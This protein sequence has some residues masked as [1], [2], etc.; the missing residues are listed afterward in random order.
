VTLFRLTDSGRRAA[1]L[2]WFY[3]G[4]H[5]DDEK[6]VFADLCRLVDETIEL[7]KKDGRALPRPMSVRDRF[8]RS[9]NIA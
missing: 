6:K 2:A 1:Q 9:L 8:K 5:G 7:Y 4:C 3:G